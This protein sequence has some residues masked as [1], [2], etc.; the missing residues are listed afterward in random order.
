MRIADPP[1]EGRVE[2]AVAG[3]RVGRKVDVRLVN[4]DP[5]RGY[6]EFRVVNH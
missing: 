4:T 6:I 3:L 5:Y 2:G 1:V